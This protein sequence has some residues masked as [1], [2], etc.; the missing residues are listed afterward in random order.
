MKLNHYGFIVMAPDYQPEKQNAI[1][2]N[3]YFRTE[4]AGVSTVEE[5]VD[6]AGEMIKRGIQVIELCGAFGEDNANK[7]IDSLDTK[8]PVGFVGFSMKEEEKL[9]DFLASD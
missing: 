7:V 2:E 6:V 9:S 3:E 1:L 5:A 8:V 4:V